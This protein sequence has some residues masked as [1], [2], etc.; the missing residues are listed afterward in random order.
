MIEIRPWLCVGKHVEASNLALLEQHKITAMLLVHQSLKTIGIPLLFVPIQDGV[1][2]RSD[3]LER[4]VAFIR[5]QKSEGRNV[6]VACSAGISRSVTFATAA[7]KLEEDLTLHD[8]FH[9]LREKH[10]AALPDQVLWAGL[11]K[12][13]GEEIS[14]W[15][16]WRETME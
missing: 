1:P 2:L 10:P 16:I 12:Y 4:G 7:L 9:A 6:L 3:K 11:C 15:D 8:A 13:F 5:E 14:F